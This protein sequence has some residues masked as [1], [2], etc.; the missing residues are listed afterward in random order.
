MIKDLFKK[1]LLIFH[2]NDKIWHSRSK[3]PNVAP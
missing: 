2:D 3:N 1:E